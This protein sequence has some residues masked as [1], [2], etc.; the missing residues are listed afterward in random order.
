MKI[1]ATP[2]EARARVLARECE[3]YRFRADHKIMFD[4]VELESKGSNVQRG[5]GHR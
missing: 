1:V 4:G 5:F 2:E 3:L